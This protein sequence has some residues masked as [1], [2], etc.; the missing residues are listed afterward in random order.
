MGHLAWLLLGFFKDAVKRT[1]VKTVSALAS[2]KSIK[3]VLALA[4]CD[5]AYSNEAD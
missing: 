1:N 5:N 3:T 4:H 2:G